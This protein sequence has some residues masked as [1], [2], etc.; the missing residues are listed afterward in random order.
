MRERFRP[1]CHSYDDARPA[2]PASAPPQSV[3]H[4]TPAESCRALLLAPMLG[5]GAVQRR[6]G[7]C[8][9]LPLSGSDSGTIKARPEDIR[10]IYAM[11]GRN[12]TLSSF[13]KNGMASSPCL[14]F[15]AR[16]RTVRSLSGM[17]G[18]SPPRIYHLAAPSLPRFKVLPPRFKVLP[19]RFGVHLPKLLRFSK[20][21]FRWTHPRLPAG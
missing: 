3:G 7:P 14:I 13:C 12:C 19:P 18:N 1:D 5:A 2:R 20:S 9:P 8:M 6:W 11:L 21:L 10:R 4:V 15:S 16:L 17:R